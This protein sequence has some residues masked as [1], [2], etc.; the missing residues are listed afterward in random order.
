MDHHRT[1]DLFPAV[2]KEEGP[3]REQ[4]DRA[5]SASNGGVGGGSIELRMAAAHGGVESGPM[6]SAEK[7][8]D[9]QVERLPD[10]AGGVIAK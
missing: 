10:G 7:L 1:D 3:A 4:L 6:S 2:P 9:D 5:A 8:G